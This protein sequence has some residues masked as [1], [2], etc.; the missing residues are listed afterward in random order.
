MPNFL[1]FAV[2]VVSCVLSAFP[3]RFSIKYKSK[4]RLER[5][6]VHRRL[7][8]VTFCSRVIHGIHV[9]L[10]QHFA[11]FNLARLIKY[12]EISSFLCSSHNKTEKA[13]HISIVCEGQVLSYKTVLLTKSVRDSKEFSRQQKKKTLHR[14]GGIFSS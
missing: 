11:R 12:S 8:R 1:Y 9:I 4:E 14:K 10:Y 5:S 13:D 7:L 3:A 6:I 2:S